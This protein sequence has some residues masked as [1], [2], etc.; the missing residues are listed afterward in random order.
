MNALT[1]L[2]VELPQG[3][4][5]EEAQVALAVRLFQTGKASLGQAAG[6]AALS[7]RAFIDLLGR[8]GLPVGSDSADELRLESRTWEAGLDAMAADPQMHE[9]LGRIAEEFRSSEADGLAKY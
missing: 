3:I 9:E 7:E 5:R 4:T 2:T 8:E 6:M 1:E